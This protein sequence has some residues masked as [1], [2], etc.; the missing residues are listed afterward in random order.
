[1]KRG[2][3]VLAEE[4]GK[5]KISELKRKASR[6]LRKD[7]SHLVMVISDSEKEIERELRYLGIVFYQ[8]PLDGTREECVRDGI[9]Y[10]E[11]VCDTICSYAANP[12]CSASLQTLKDAKDSSGMG[13]PEYEEGRKET[14]ENAQ[15]LWPQVRVRLMR[16]SKFFGPGVADLMR[17]IQF[18]GSVKTACERLSL[19]YSKGMQMIRNAEKEMQT[20]LVTRRQ[21]GISGGMAEL[22]EDGK[23]LLDTYAK[24]EEAVVKYA[25]EIFP[26]YFH[27]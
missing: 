7:I 14:K 2:M 17:Q 15:G 26:S 27:K 6:F 3:I 9:G 19:S 23:C 1:M 10:L 12:D 8:F 21:G 11:S 5:D 22:T 20:E 13:I 18:T 4:L 16:N 25:E 24:Y